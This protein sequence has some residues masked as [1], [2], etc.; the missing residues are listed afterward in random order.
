MVLS[1]KEI[2]SQ[3]LLDR[4]LVQSLAGGNTTSAGTPSTIDRKRLRWHLNHSLSDRQKQVIRY[5][6]MGKKEREIAQL[7]GI[8]QQVVN[9]YKQRAIRKLRQI[10]S[11]NHSSQASIG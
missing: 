1:P 3:Q 8:K 9:I 6:L 10:F 2:A 11:S 5:Y 4:L 7:L